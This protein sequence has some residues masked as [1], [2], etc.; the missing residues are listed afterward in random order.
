MK[1]SELSE[2]E[3]ACFEYYEEESKHSESSVLKVF[4]YDKSISDQLE[5]E[6]K[7]VDMSKFIGSNV[8]MEFW[9]HEEYT[10][11][12]E[13]LSFLTHIKGLRPSFVD[14]VEASYYCCRPKL[15][16]VNAWLGGENPLPD[17]L[18]VKIH[19]VPNKHCSSVDYQGGN[20]YLQADWEDIRAFEILGLA[21]GW[22]W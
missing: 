12:V 22:S 18:H 5:P 19:Y 15:N 10:D 6:V 1:R 14:H 2:A 21:D 3:L 20:G 9:D 4:S 16:Y 8:L 11:D 13:V 7:K 17:G